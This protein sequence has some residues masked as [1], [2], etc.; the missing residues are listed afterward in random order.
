MSSI[1][2]PNSIK[3]GRKSEDTSQIMEMKEFTSF[4]FCIQAGNLEC[5]TIS[6]RTG[7]LKETPLIRDKGVSLWL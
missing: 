3:F 6:K 2:I 4:F 5:W 7:E 1:I